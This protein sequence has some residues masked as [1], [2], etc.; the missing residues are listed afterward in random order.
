MTTITAAITVD[1]ESRDD[2]ELVSGLIEHL[3]AATNNGER[4]VVVGWGTAVEALAT[5]EACA[6]RGDYQNAMADQASFIRA[7]I[8]ELRRVTA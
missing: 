2:A 7:A 1:D 4:G 6:K 3:R 5:M 8:V